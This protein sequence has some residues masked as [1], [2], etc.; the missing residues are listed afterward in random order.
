MDYSLDE[1]VVVAE[2]LPVPQ[3]MKRMKMMKMMKLVHQLH[4][5]NWVPMAL[6]ELEHHSRAIAYSLELHFEQDLADAVGPMVLTQLGAQKSLRHLVHHRPSLLH[7]CRHQQRLP[8]SR[9]LFPFSRQLS[10]PTHRARSLCW[11]WRLDTGHAS[12]EQPVAQE[13]MRRTSRTRPIL[14]I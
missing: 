9:S 2:D 5:V 10:S 6:D 11:E 8:S 4:L 1:I 14:A 12:D 13:W 7:L 3:L